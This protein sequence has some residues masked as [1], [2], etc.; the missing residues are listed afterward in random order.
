MYTDVYTFINHEVN[1]IHLQ[2]KNKRLGQR[3]KDS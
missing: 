2:P 1:S 3:K